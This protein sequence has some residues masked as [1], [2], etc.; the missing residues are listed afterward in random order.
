MIIP[1]V[2]AVIESNNVY[3]RFLLTSKDDSN[4]LEVNNRWEFPGGKVELN[5]SLLAALA[6]EIREELE[7]DLDL[8][9]FPPTLL[10][11]QINKYS[12]SKDY[13]LVLFYKCRSKGKIDIMKLPKHNWITLESITDYNTLPGAIDALQNLYL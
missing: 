2:A 13:Y 3:G 5:E 11:A 7:I 9:K 6:R 10:H 4:H 1:V 12:Y 8:D